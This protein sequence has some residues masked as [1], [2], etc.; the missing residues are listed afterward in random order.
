MKSIFFLT[1]I[2]LSIFA[3]AEVILV[4]APGASPI[5]YENYLRQTP[6]AVS[7]IDYQQRRIQNQPQQEQ[8]IFALGDSFATSPDLTLMHL[9]GSQAGSP[10]T[11]MSLR[12][13][14]DLS[15]RSLATATRPQ[16]RELQNLYCKSA[17]LLNEGPLSENCS[18]Q[19]ISMD[20]LRKKFPKAEK[21][22]IESLGFSLNDPVNPTIASQANYHWTFLS[23]SGRAVS[24]FGTYE[25]LFQQSLAFSDIV[26]GGCEGFTTDFDDLTLQTAAKIY[27][28]ESC[29]RSPMSPEGNKMAWVKQER[30][31][32]VAAGLVVLGGIAYSLKDKQVSINMPGLK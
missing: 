30:T 7:Y 25:Q 12:F 17:V 1:I 26:N 22:M 21:V 32:W 20:I 11:L 27:F 15:E 29:Q 9:K 2:F 13:A 31:W 10:W 18:T 5:A 4:R 16:R 19:Y 28:S 3:Q 23:N 6:Q 8:Q 14:R 24:F